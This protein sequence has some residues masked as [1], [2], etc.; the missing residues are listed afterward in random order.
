[1]RKSRIKHFEKKL[2]AKFQE[3]ARDYLKNKEYGL[4]DRDLGAHDFLDLAS[5]SYF[6]ET[7]LSLSEKEQQQL[8][9]IEE[10]MRK[11]PSG[12]YG[13]CVECQESIS[14][15]RLEALAWARHCLKCQELEE[16]GLL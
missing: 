9:L 4:R 8:R 13:K 10:A 15:K 16:K 2:S 6:A 3:V 11:I 12:D 7:C 5:D 14:D 1:M